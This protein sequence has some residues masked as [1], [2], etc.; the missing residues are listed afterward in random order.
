[1]MNLI[2]LIN[3]LLEPIYDQIVKR[4]RYFKG[5]N[6]IQALETSMKNSHLR[7]STLF[8]TLHVKNI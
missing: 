8:V 2:P 7:S 6:A 3:R 5:A 4:I 1:M